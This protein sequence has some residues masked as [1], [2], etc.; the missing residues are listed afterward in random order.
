[1]ANK[2]PWIVGAA[3]LVSMAAG[4]GAGYFAAKHRLTVEFE[5]RLDEEL[6]NTK[7]FYNTLHKK[8]EYETPQKAAE[9]LI[10]GPPEDNDFVPDPVVVGTATI[11]T[12][13]GGH[14]LNRQLVMKETIEERNVFIEAEL[15]EQGVTDRDWTAE[16]MKRTEEAPYV[17]SKD[18]FMQNESDYQQATMTYYSGDVVLTDE[19]ENVIEETDEVVGDYNLVRFGHWSEDPNVVYVRNDIRELEMEICLNKGNYSEIVQGLTG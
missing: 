14:D 8:G 12:Q 10:P 5:A 1:M 19:H 13:Y 11:L 6:E 7:L 2:T 4:A 15:K 3:C 17:I 18:E 9:K 16:V